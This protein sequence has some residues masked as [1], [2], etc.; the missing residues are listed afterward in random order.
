MKFKVWNELNGNC[1]VRKCNRHLVYTPILK[2]C[3]F[4]HH[5]ILQIHLF[6][7][8]CL[9]SSVFIFRSVSCPTSCTCQSK[10]GTTYTFTSSN[11]KQTYSSEMW[12]QTSF[13]NISEQWR[14]TSS[15]CIYDKEKQTNKILQEKI[16]SKFSQ[17]FK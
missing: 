17:C 12:K 8:R 1:Y 14:L 5:Y 6:V 2:T 13:T 4:H 7:I 9:Q 10:P 15:T 11:G 16:T 3:D